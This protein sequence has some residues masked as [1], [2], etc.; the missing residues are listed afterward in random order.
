MSTTLIE[1]L[2][3]AGDAVS[4]KILRV[5]A[6][7]DLEG[8]AQPLLLDCAGKLQTSLP[9]DAFGR[10][11]GS[12]PDVIVSTTNVHDDTPH[13][14]Q[15]SLTGGGTATRDASSACV[16]MRTTTASG[17]KVVRQTRFYIPY[18]PGRSLL[19]LATAN[20]YGAVSDQRKRIGWFDASDGIFLEL[21]GATVRL[22]RRTSASGSVVENQVPRTSW[23][24]DPLDGT[25][26][27]GI[28]LDLTKTLIFWQDCEWLG[29][30]TVRWGVVID[31]QFYCAHKFHH[32][33]V[34]TVVY[35]STGNLPF[36]LELENT[37]GGSAGSVDQ[38]CF[39]ALLEGGSEGTFRRDRAAVLG[40][41]KV[42]ASQNA[43]TPLL[44]YRLK[45]SHNKAVLV[46]GDFSAVAE[47][48]TKSFYMRLYV[49]P[50]GGATGG[51]WSSASDAVE[52]KIPTGVNLTGA[53]LI[54][55]GLGGVSDQ[56]ASVSLSAIGAV[57][58]DIS[59]AVDEVVLTVTPLTKNSDFWGSCS[60][61]EVY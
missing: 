32:S 61:Q 4:G 12:E 6:G 47:D 51:S 7:K 48:G 1:K 59:G 19:L 16:Q 41:S 23:N 34:L 46:P 53:R 24:V 45:S 29:V 55:A 17:D 26:P 10:V 60:W 31:G 49:V 21:S 50:P 52:S 30:G 3:S 25:G 9:L 44:A 5:M 14:W 28:T 11:R 54:G 20:L 58:R 18:Q 13:L 27:S 39:S 35:T 2:R 40:T 42:S 33:N 8:N 43:N 15:N 56:S 36:R 37:A 22:V 57:G 38:I